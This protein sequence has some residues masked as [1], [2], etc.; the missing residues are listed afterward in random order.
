MPKN[1]IDYSNTIIYKIY[2]KDSNIHDVY[3]G[4]TT[5]FIKRK[6]MHKSSCNSLNYKYKIYETIRNNGGWENWEMVELAKYNCKD[7]LEARIK[8][9]Q[10]YELLNCSLNSSPPFV[11]KNKYFCKTCKLQCQTS[12]IYEKHIV[13]D[14]HSKKI[15]ILT[16]KNA[17][18]V[19][20]LCDFK[21]NK[22]SEYIRHTNTIKHIHR[23]EG[24][25][26]E[27]KE[28]NIAQLWTCSCGKE[29]ATRAGLW[30]HNKVCKIE[31][32]EYNNICNNIDITNVQMLTNM[33]FEVVKQNSET[34]KQN[35]DL[36]NK[37]YE[38]SKNSQITNN[39]T[40][41]NSH[42]KSFNLQFFL[43]ETCKNAMN[44]SEFVDS[45]QLQLSDLEKV[46]ELGY[47]EG[48]SNIIIKNLNAL[49]VTLRPV[50]CTDKKR[51]TMYIKDED[52]WEKEDENKVKLHKMVRKVANKNIDLISDFKKLY[53]DWKKCSSRVSDQ[54]NKIVIESMGG[55]GDNDFEKEEKIIKRVAKEVL[56]NK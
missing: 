38:L 51:E 48:I 55:S 56:V 2:C 19:C 34:Q 25:K 1:E 42:N 11:D 17:K 50:H 9:Q 47:I 14:S 36:I 15:C 53:P 35:Q 6:C 13:S 49:D 26:M 40:N 24:N 21:C 41:N 39:T 31:K 12:K 3:V 27:T 44:I 33:V 5:N 45:L 20:E 22:K 23:V 54:F 10:H 29:Y 18:F 43:N 8:E 32:E 28:T 4:H 52:K 30:K 37:L 16:P 46:G 7:N